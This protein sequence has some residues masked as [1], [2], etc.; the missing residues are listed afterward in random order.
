MSIG[1][2]GIVDA[3]R[4]RLPDEVIQV[5]TDVLRAYAQDH[6]PEDFRK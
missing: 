4:A 6:K 2:P 3:L 1:R 5:D